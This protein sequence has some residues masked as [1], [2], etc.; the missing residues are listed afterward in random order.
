MKDNLLP[1]VASNV[2]TAAGSLSGDPT[3]TLSTAFLAPIAVSVVKDLAKGS[4][5]RLILPGS[6]GS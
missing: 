4:W 6:V 5:A 2:I 1:A 3:I